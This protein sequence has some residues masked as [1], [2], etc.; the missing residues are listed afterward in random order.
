MS[1]S[2][3]IH[4]KKA[5]S[6][7]VSYHG[8]AN[9][10]GLLGAGVTKYDKPTI[11]ERIQNTKEKFNQKK[12]EIKLEKQQPSN[13]GNRTISG[14]AKAAAK[15]IL[16]RLHERSKENRANYLTS[17][18]NQ[19]YYMKQNNNSPYYLQ[20][21]GNNTSPFLNSGEK[22]EKTKNIIIKITK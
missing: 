1:I 4:K 21:S 14:R 17:N 6:F 20:S 19:P 18:N 7:N 11:S 3:L 15:G 16:T 8:D 22:K 5:M 10:S 13:I 9:R 12:A 2:G